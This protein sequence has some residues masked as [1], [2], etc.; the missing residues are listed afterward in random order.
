MALE[1]NEMGGASNKN[2]EPSRDN[3]NTNRNVNE[4]TEEVGLLL[5]FIHQKFIKSPIEYY[6][7]TFF[8]EFFKITFIV[9]KSQTMISNEEKTQI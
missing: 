8:S 9:I 7:H 4:E 6:I 5:Y 3:R 2:T 1:R